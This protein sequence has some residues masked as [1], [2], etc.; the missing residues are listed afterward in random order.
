MLMLYKQEILYLKMLLMNWVHKLKHKIRKY[1]NWYTYEDMQDIWINGVDT[2]RD[3]V[4][5]YKFKTNN[6]NPTEALDEYNK[7][8]SNRNC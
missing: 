5:S 8:R 3:S 7:T 4:D 6:F 1:F 2:G